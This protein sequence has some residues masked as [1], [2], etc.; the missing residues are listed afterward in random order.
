MPRGHFW[1]LRAVGFSS[2]VSL[3][4]GVVPACIKHRETVI[5]RALCVSQPERWSLPRGH[6]DAPAE[7][8]RLSAARGFPFSERA[9]G[10]H[11]SARAKGR[12][13]N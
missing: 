7:Q 1:D 4:A 5:F 9:V 6:V 10:P 2:A 13:T 11:E 8:D 3:V 12:F